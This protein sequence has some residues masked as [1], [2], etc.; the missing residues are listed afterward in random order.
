MAVLSPLLFL[1][2]LATGIRADAMDVEDDVGNL[3]RLDM[4]ARRIVALSPHATELLFAAGA[5]KHL[6]AATAY[7]DYP[8]EARTLPQVGDAARLDRER[9][10]STRPDLVVAWPS[11]NQGKDL[12]W[13]RGRGI[14][15]YLSEPADLEAIADNILDLGRLAGTEN[16]ARE[17]AR[18]FI[19]GLD[20]IRNRYRDREESLVFVQVWARPL[21][22]VGADH[23]ILK[24]LALC[25]GRTLFPELLTPAAGVSREAVIRANPQVILAA[26]APDDTDDPFAQW[27]HWANIRAVNS[28]R[29]IRVSGDYISR[30]TPRILRG[31]EQACGQL[32]YQ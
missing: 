12:A 31:A 27:R 28:N 11:G 13:L 1:L 32:H 23:L 15:L 29:L 9:L 17:A 25:G 3:V 4:P 16:T 5:G 26:V 22:T 18:I 20:A 14:P 10:L 2:L 21:I 8:P 19:Q 30:A 6:V 24:A 7:S